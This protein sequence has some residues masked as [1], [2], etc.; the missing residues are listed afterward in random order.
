[1]HVLAGQQRP[2]VSVGG[3]ELQF[4]CRCRGDELIVTVMVPG[5]D[6]DAIPEILQRV[7]RQ[8]KQYGKLD[9]GP[10]CADGAYEFLRRATDGL[11]VKRVGEVGWNSRGW[12]E[13]PVVFPAQ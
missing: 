6:P 7:G 3:G 11:H 5:G 12:H 1:M 8:F 2:K 9:R 10:D 13:L 4:D